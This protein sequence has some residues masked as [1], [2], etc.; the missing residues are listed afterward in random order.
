MFLGAF[1]N[2]ALASGLLFHSKVYYLA[3][4][5]ICKTVDVNIR[6]QNVGGV[7]GESLPRE[8]DLDSNLS[9]A[10]SQLQDLRL[11]IQSL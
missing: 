9:S 7:R 6:R 3:V 2:T 8:S 4:L 5:R 11:T 1:Q 10:V